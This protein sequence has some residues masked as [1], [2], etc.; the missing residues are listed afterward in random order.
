QDLRAAA[1]RLYAD[2]FAADPQLAD[3]LTAHCVRRTRGSE[4]PA[5]RI[6]VFNSVSRYSAARCAASAG[7]GLGKDGAK[8]GAEERARWRNQAREWL[9]ADLAAWA[10]LMHTDSR[11]DRDLARRMLT[12]WQVEPDLA[13]LRELGA[14]DKLSTEER[15]DCLA[16]WEEVGVV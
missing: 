6:E 13:G 5:D 4:A 14:L 9:R 15:M 7:C 2:A 12:H 16:L 3:E 11:V 10:K 1:A 8:L